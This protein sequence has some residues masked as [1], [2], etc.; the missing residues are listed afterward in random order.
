MV[1]WRLVNYPELSP[2]LFKNGMATKMVMWRLV[3]SPQLR[4]LLISELNVNKE[5]IKEF[6]PNKNS[7]DTI[8]MKANKRGIVTGKVLS[9]AGEFSPSKSLLVTNNNSFD[10]VK[11][12]ANKESVVTDEVLSGAGEFS[13][14]KS[15]L[16]TELNAKTKL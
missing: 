15:L 16:I 6:S 2:H 3:S 8:K 4:C 5:E 1:T 12:N 9:G 7:F 10:A 14:A 13:R 11:M